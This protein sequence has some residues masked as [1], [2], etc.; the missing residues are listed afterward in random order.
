MGQ[1]LWIGGILVALGVL[2]S[3]PALRDG[4]AGGQPRLPLAAD[5]EV[6]I[7]FRGEADAAIPWELRPTRTEVPSLPGDVVDSAFRIRSRANRRMT[8][9]VRHAVEPKEVAK[10]LTLVDCSLLTTATLDP[11]EEAV[12]PVSYF[13]RPGYPGWVREFQVTYTLSVLDSEVGRQ[14]LMAGQKIYAERCLSC[15]GEWGKGDGPVGSLLRP[16]PRDLALALR[17]LSESDLLRVV[18][19]GRGAMPAFAPALSDGDLRQVLLYV[20][21]L[22]GAGG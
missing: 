20:R 22:A 10:Y 3:R 13:L 4:V 12:F 21:T 15:H 9:F 11:G 14:D 5:R 6:E 18:R 7:R 17:G 19:T 8:A 1:W 2:A 16:P